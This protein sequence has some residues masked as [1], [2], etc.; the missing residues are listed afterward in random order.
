MSK[1]NEDTVLTLKQIQDVIQKEVVEPATKGIKEEFDK[2]KKETMEA[3]Q[4]RFIPQLEGTM[5]DGAGTTFAGSRFDTSVLSS[6]KSLNSFNDHEFASGFVTGGFFRKLSPAMALFAQ[7]LAM[8][9]KIDLSKLTEACLAQKKALGLKAASGMGEANVGFDIPIEFPSIII[10]AAVATSPILA[11]LWRFP[12]ADSVVSIPRLSQSDSD[13]FGGVFTEWSGRATSGEGTTMNATAPTTTKN[14]FYA[15]KC[16]MMVILTDELIQDA[17]INILNYV[18]GLLVRKFTYELERVVIAGNGKSEPTGI[19]VDSTVV[20]NAVARA[21]SGDLSYKDIIKLDGELNEIFKSPYLITRKKTIAAL[22]GQV[23]NTGR[24]IWFEGWGMHNGT[25]TLVSEILGIP[26]H[27]TRNCPA[28]GTQGDV[29]EGDLSMYMLGMRQD[30]R[31]DIS[32][33]PGFTKNE[34]YVRFI[35]RLDGMPG[36]PFAFKILDGTHS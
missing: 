32:D 11:K 1:E 7:A 28:L 25:P 3:T 35:A 19:T 17:P 20:A 36:T 31:I 10:E 13:Y 15:K 33:A 22:R 12:M 16:T 4:K 21:K 8:K 24:P 27:V 29:I 6:V 5:A 30:M 18:T 34:T 23:D 14:E 2:F 9:G 26:Y